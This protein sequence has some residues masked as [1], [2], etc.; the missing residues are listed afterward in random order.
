MLAFNY[1]VNIWKKG[2]TKSYIQAGI[3][4]G[5]AIATKYHVGIIMVPF[6]V[7]HFFR[8]GSKKDHG[9]KLLYIFLSFLR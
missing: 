5:A 2:D 1:V 3:I 8:E 6:I 9:V 4:S 7:A